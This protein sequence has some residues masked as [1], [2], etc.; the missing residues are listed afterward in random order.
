ME[1]SN[2]HTCNLI[3]KGLVFTNLLF[4]YIESFVNRTLYLTKVPNDFVLGI[5]RYHICNEL[6][7]EARIVS[8][9]GSL[10]LRV[11]VNDKPVHLNSRL[12]RSLYPLIFIEIA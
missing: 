9:L 11:P 12:K 8:R 5:A 6:I 10:H 7:D 2:V 3:K 1:G 4:E